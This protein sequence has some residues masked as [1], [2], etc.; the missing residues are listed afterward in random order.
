MSQEWFVVRDGKETGP[1]TLAALKVRAA[2]GFLSP[3]SMIRRIDAEKPVKASTI[4]GL[5]PTNATATEE[6]SPL[7]NDRPTSD[8]RTKKSGP[9]KKTIIIASIA[10]CA[11]LLFCCGGLSLVGIFGMKLKEATRKE[12]AEADSLWN[13]GEK[14]EA[15]GKYRSILDGSKVTYLKDDERSRVYGRVIDADMEKGN[16]DSAKKLIAEATKNK[17]TLSV[18]HPEALKLVA[19]E[20]ARANGDKKSAS[21]P[22]VKDITLAGGR[23]PMDEFI[24]YLKRREK[25]ELHTPKNGSDV[26]GTPLERFGELLGEK[27]RVHI[28]GRRDFGQN[29]SVVLV[30]PVKDG[31]VAAVVLGTPLDLSESPTRP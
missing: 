4:K 30:E 10:S 19:A 16:T 6:S 3:N 21:H 14:T 31:K 9:S 25:L 11:C 28:G 7:E 13:K 5:F 26:S 1:F 18:S 24:E 27:C 23:V 2:K 20:Q 12:L 15:I 22:P 8:A 29:V 17:V